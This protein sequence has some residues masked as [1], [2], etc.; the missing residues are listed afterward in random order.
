MKLRLFVDGAARGNPGPAAIGV[1]VQDGRGRV[2][3]EVGETLGETTNNVAEY[4]A[5]LRGLREARKRKADDLEIRTDSDLLVRQI[6]GTYRVKSPHLIPLH[7][8]AI[9]ALGVFR[10]WRIA[11][12]PRTANAAADALANKAL[13]AAD[14]GPVTPRPPASRRR[15]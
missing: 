1:V 5:L 3:A 6:N 2:I 9:A 15:P 7:G 14:Q 12:I 11:H 4:R 8:E 13:D 10:R